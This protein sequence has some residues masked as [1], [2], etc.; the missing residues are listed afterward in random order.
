MQEVI[1]A[2]DHAGVF[3]ATHLCEFAKALGLEVQSFIPQLQQKVDYPDYAALVC[4]RLQG[5]AGA[6]GVLVCGSGIGMS[7]AANRYT[8]IRAALCSEPLSAALSRRHNDSNVLC[9]GERLVGA[10]MAK[11]IFEAFVRTD[12]EGGRHLS[13]VQKLNSLALNGGKNVR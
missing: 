4:Q 9:L 12:F 5:R 10:D 3:L 1:I 8:H 13:R 2:S 6:F 11:A 7:M